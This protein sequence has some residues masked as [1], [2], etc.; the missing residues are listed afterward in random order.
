MRHAV[1]A[2]PSCATFPILRGSLQASTV[3]LVTVLLTIFSA[4]TA[5]ATDGGAQIDAPEGVT[6]IWIDIQADTLSAEQV[7]LKVSQG[8]KGQPV[9]FSPTTFG[10]GS[11]MAISPGKLTITGRVD[12]NER[13]VLNISLGDESGRILLSQSLLLTNAGIDPTP[14]P[15]GTPSSTPTSTPTPSPSPA[16]PDATPSGTSSASPT[17]GPIG[18]SPSVSTQATGTTT[19]PETSDHLAAT[20]A[21]LTPLVVVAALIAISG[22]LV[23]GVRKAAR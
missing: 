23:L 8:D 3:L 16:T 20:G 7:S 15:S 19:R 17:S 11:R 2:T 12:T 14:E 4:T 5:S 22:A 21:P 18:S 9:E 1:R 6:Q 13:V 10:M